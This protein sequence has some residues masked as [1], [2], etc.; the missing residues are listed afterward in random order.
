MKKLL[1]LIPDPLSGIIAKGE[2]QPL[3]YNPGNF[4]DE[5]H[6]VMTEDD[7]VEPNQLQFTVGDASL[8]IHTLPIQ[9]ENLIQNTFIFRPWLLKPWA[10]PVLRMVNRFQ[11]KLLKRWAQGAIALAKQ[12]QPHIIRCHGNDYNAYAALQIKKELGIPYIVSLHINPDVNSRRRVSSPV[13]WQDR[14]FSRLFDE[15]ERAGLLGADL[16]LPVYE[17]IISYLERMRCTQY[18]VAYNVLSPHLQKKVSYDL[19]AP[20][21]LIS[22]GR[23]FELKNPENILRAV[24]KISNVHFTLVGDGPLQDNLI[25]LAKELNLGE[26]VT[27]SPAVPNPDLCQLLSDSDI[28]VI[29]TEHWEMSK[30]LLEALL[31]GLPIILNQREGIGGDPPELLKSDFVHF[32]QNTV[33]GYQH[34]IMDLISDHAERK[35]LGRAAYHVAQEKWAPEKTEA[36]Y[37]EVYQR[38]MAKNA[39][40]K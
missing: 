29:H 15:V 39:Q 27:F 19:R 23:H 7:F 21:R 2:F 13:T 30:S 20:V 24:Q 33:E 22:V 38:I 18:E 25:S 17:P 34:A 35:R 4:F 40:R 37:V 10:E 9:P 12:I 3:Y 8:H 14:L 32:V 36:K 26:K 28:F 6:I 11:F 1:V 16:A 31:T 5:V